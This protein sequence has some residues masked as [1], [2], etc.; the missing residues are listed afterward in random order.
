MNRR[1][2]S[3]AATALVFAAVLSSCSSFGPVLAEKHYSEKTGQLDAGAVVYPYASQF[4]RARAL[5]HAACAGGPLSFSDPA[6]AVVSAH[7]ETP[8][9]QGEEWV[10]GSEVVRWQRAYRI[11]FSCPP[12][13]AK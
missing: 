1:H 12:E 13:P 6:L 2:W 11:S 7:F 5:A 9:E 10:F 3:L 4:G 8:V